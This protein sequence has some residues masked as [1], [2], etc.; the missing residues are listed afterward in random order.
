MVV[1]QNG[2]LRLVLTAA[3]MLVWLLLAMRAWSGSERPDGITVYSPPPHRAGSINNGVVYGEHNKPMYYI[4]GN[5]IYSPDKPATPIGQFKSDV[6]PP[7]CP[8]N[9]K[10]CK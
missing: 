1:H 4:H 10:D 9:R 6:P 7:T 3:F 5:T 2:V 8:L